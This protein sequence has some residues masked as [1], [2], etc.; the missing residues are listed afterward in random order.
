MLSEKQI[1]HILENKLI[2]ECSKSEKDQVF[3]FAFGNDFMNSKTK[4][5][6]VT[7]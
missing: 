4:G 1:I 6:K 7:K 3:S 2:N 5:K